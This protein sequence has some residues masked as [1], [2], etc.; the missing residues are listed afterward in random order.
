MY[1]ICRSCWI[2]VLVLP[3]HGFGEA[4]HQTSKIHI[5]FVYYPNNTYLVH[6]NPLENGRRPIIFLITLYLQLIVMVLG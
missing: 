3:T 5:L 6:W 1:S 4:I 2:T